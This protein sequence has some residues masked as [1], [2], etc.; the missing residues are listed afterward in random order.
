LSDVEE[1]D[2]GIASSKAMARMVDNVSLLTCTVF[3]IE[4]IS[5]YKVKAELIKNTQHA[6]P[7]YGVKVVRVE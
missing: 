3:I 7:K 6:N 5:I 1:L 4:N 2:L